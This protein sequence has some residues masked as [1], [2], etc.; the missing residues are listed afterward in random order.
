MAEI[1]W[2]QGLQDTIQSMTNGPYHCLV[3][4]LRHTSGQRFSFSPY[5]RAQSR[6]EIAQGERWAGFTAPG[7][8][9][10]DEQAATRAK[11]VS[12]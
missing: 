6:S 7:C 9:L 11:A 4:R 1:T 2:W 10:C 5:R 8:A 12:R 3:P